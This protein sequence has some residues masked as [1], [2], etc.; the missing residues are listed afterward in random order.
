MLL[1]HV[2][3][4]AGHRG[5]VVAG[6]EVLKA[7]VL[8]QA[9]ACIAGHA[10]G[11]AIGGAV[12]ALCQLAVGAGALL[13]D[14]CVSRGRLVAS[15]GIADAGAAVI[16]HL[17]ASASVAAGA[18]HGLM[19]VASG[20]RGSGAGAGSAGALLHDAEVAGGVHDVAG[21]V[22]A[23]RALVHAISVASRA[24]GA[25]ARALAVQQAGALL[26]LAA[27]AVSLEDVPVRAGLALPG[28]V[29]G[30]V[31]ALGRRAGARVAGAQ[32][33]DAGL[34]VNVHHVAPCSG[35]AGA[36]Q[37]VV[38]GAVGALCRNASAAGAGADLAL[39]VEVAGQVESRQAGLTLVGQVHL[40]V[41]THG[42]CARGRVAVAAV[43]IS[44]GR[45]GVGDATLGGE[46][47]E[48]L[49]ALGVDCTL[50]VHLAVDPRIIT[51]GALELITCAQLAVKGVALPL[52][53]TAGRTLQRQAFALRQFAFFEQADA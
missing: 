43:G 15:A 16:G 19:G 45:V 53:R 31:N 23:A 7:L 6:A 2:A 38:G 10:L 30:A 1:V 34:P 49:V 51:I 46:A 42:S 20:P 3:G 27:Q 5:A 50:Q 41:G 11:V 35:A 18:F 37:R 12:G 9:E 14:T 44:L 33:L 21:R 22:V 17:E 40:A 29:G 47:V 24:T 4:G 52:V 28:L 8:L 25:L 39:A 48:G 36:V 32:L 13:E 26:L